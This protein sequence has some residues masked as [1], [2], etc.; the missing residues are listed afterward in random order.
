[1]VYTEVKADNEKSKFRSV[2][3]N[4]DKFITTGL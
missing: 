3:E 1:M 2:P 4:R